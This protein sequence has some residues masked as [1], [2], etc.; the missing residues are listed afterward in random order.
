VASAAPQ[1]GDASLT[2]M[3]WSQQSSSGNEYAAPAY[4]PAPAP[5]KPATYKPATYKP[6]TYAPTYKPQY[7]TEGPAEYKFSYDVNA[8]ETNDVKSQSESLKDGYTVGQY[9]LI[10]ADGMRRTVDYTADDINGFQATVRRE[11]VKNN[12]PSYSAPQNS[13]PKYQQSAY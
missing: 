2:A 1:Y 13:A 3:Q 10:D 5:Y 6:A 7:E 9:S 4:K 8:P 11:P 12:N